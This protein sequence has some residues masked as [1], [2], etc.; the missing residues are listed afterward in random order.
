ME[1]LKKISTFAKEQDVSVQTVYNWIKKGELQ[2][3]SIDNVKFIKV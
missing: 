2:C 1:N 3:V